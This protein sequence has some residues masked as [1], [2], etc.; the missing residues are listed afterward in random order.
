MDSFRRCRFLCTTLLLAGCF[1][2]FSPAAQQVLAQNNRVP[3]PPAP[4][5]PVVYGLQWDQTADGQLKV[6]GVYD[7]SAAAQAGFRAGDVI[8]AINNE[9]MSTSRQ[10]AKTLAGHR[11][12]AKIEVNV[13]RGEEPLRLTLVADQTLPLLAT[14]EESLSIDE[15]MYGWTLRDAPDGGVAVQSAAEGSAASRLGVR[16]GD[17]IVAVGGMQTPTRAAFIAAFRELLSRRAGQEVPVTVVRAGQEVAIP[18]TLPQAPAAA[19]APPPTPAVI[20][21][22]ADDSGRVFGM[23]VQETAGGLVIRS[24]L[25]GS[26]AAKAGLLPGD[27]LLSVGRNKVSTF[28][29]LM[30]AFDILKPTPQIPIQFARDAEA[31]E[32]MLIVGAVVVPPAVDYAK[33]FEQ[34]SHVVVGG[35]KAIYSFDQSTADWQTSSRVA[36]V[37][38]ATVEKGEGIDPGQL[39]YA[40]YAITRRLPA[41]GEEAATPYPNVRD[42]FRLY[43]TRAADGGYDVIMPGGVQIITG[44]ARSPLAPVSRGVEGL[45]LL[46]DLPQPG[47]VVDL[48]DAAGL[49]AT[50]TTNE[51]G[52]FWFDVPPGR[53]TVSAKG[54]IGPAARVA[55][56]AP[57]FVTAAQPTNMRISLR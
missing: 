44:E 10:V 28:M 13:L 46:N 6:T 24:I 56:P 47:V 27:T 9:R 52:Q 14:G 38:V 15:R 53:Y 34:A 16:P 4:Q 41:E 51:R 48:W 11:V 26:P 42:V 12:G 45:V 18:L 7:D 57:V 30:R 19:P 43:L 40:R 31:L 29:G 22:P 25:P 17:V 36:E 49:V 8:V 35:V 20:P 55:P 54:Q 37:S 5:R 2:A 32:T 39:L 23:V 33:L 50:M 1:A 3:P 21:R